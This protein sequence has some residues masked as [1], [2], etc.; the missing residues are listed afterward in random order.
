M[1]I[2]STASR[3]NPFV[4]NSV[5][6]VFPFT[7]KTLAAA[8]LLVVTVVTATGVQT[9]LVLDSGYS[10][11]LN[12]DQNASP[13]GSITYPL[14]GSPL[15]ATST[16]TIASNASDLQ[17]TQLL[18][19][20]AYN[21]D[22]ITN[23]VDLRTIIS[24]QIADAALRSIKVPVSD[25]LTLSYTLPA[26]ALRAGGFVSFDAT[27]NVI[28]AS[29]VSSVPVNVIIVPFVEAAS[30]AAAR[31]AI[32]FPAITA[33]GDLIVGTAADTLAKLAVGT[34]GQNVFADPSQTSG[35]LWVAPP[36]TP[37]NFRLSLTT[38][39]PVT[40]ADVTAATTVYLTPYNGKSILL[41]NGIGW[42]PLATGELSQL[43]TDATKSPAAVANTSVYDF[44]AW[45][46]AGTPRCTRG[47][48]WT[49]DT[50]RGAGAGTT[51][52]QSIDGRW[53]N[54]V[55]IVNG[56]AANKGLYVGS[57]RSNGSAQI[58]D[59]LALRH[60]WNNFNRRARPMRVLTAVG[61]WTYTTAAYRQANGSTAN[62]LDFVV[63][64]S[65]DE[66]IASAYGTG[67]NDTAAVNLQTG[68]GLDATNALAAGAIAHGQNNPVT[69]IPGALSAHYRGFPGIGRHFLAWLE[70]SAA[71][72]G[73]TTWAGNAGGAIQQ[74]G[75]IG[76]VQA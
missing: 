12:A 52:L 76:S 44:F 54:K 26:V 66:I 60:L 19:G 7:F 14:S 35:L 16:L 6:T 46:D 69:S 13:G 59:S 34:D 47:P 56:P 45:V 70:Y 30:L 31:L 32:G 63:G 2:S 72:V 75:I 4:G 18:N 20:G 29:G 64:L 73:T 9:T 21:A 68:I 53:V 3:T 74:N 71:G 61:S 10:V 28:I 49:S 42:V 8:D 58:N 25:P 48:A 22:V 24:H 36:L 37:S 55:A 65:E 62:Q 40:T 38:V 23:M 33:K 43:T 39:L 15:A 1:T 51:E 50:A 41:Y 11:A 17:S 27:G 57:V 67:S 5:A